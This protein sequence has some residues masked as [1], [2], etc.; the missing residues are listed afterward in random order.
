M[1]CFGYLRGRLV[2]IGYV[3]RGDAVHVF[4]MRKANSR[5]QARFG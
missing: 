1:I 5:E 4:S 2:M 3:Q